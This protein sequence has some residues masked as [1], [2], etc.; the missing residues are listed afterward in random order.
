MPSQPREFAPVSVVIPCY[1]C[2]ATISRAVESIAQ[3][4]MRPQEVI[5]VDDASGDNTLSTLYEIQARYYKGWIKVLCLPRN[6]GPSTA[7]NAGWEAARESFVAFLD[8]D[9]SW[10]PHKIEIQ[11]SW[12]EANPEVALSAHRYLLVPGPALEPDDV[13][14]PVPRKLSFRRMLL[15]NPISTPTVMLRR[16][17]P[18]RFQDGKRYAED[19]LLWL[20][21]ACQR[22]CWLLDLPLTYLHK[23]P[24]GLSG[25]SAHMWEM[26][27]GVIST[28]ETLYKE[29]RISLLTFMALVPYSLLKFLRRSIRIAFMRS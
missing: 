17:L 20:Q 10:H 24:Y 26:E 28:Y 4:V 11:F 23:A 13:N 29:H 19:Y 6:S 21:I 1:R 9:D 3:Q 2:S 22:H 12:M 16:E 5:L 8:A 7:R 25:L 15:S 27:Q 18:M 14:N